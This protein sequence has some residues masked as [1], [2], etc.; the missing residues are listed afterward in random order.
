MLS[1]TQL[2]AYSDEDLAE[3]RLRVLAELER[4][5]ALATIPTTV[6]ELAA[7]Y[8][9]GGGDPADLREALDA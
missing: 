5:E 6:A 4:R 2:R 1:P 7:R 9:E 3:L 8:T